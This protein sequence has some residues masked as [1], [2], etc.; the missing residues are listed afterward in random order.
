MKIIKKITLS[1]VITLLVFL[2]FACGKVNPPDNPVEVKE[3]TITWVSEGETLKTDKVKEG[4]MPVYVGEVPSKPIGKGVEYTF[5][6]WVP[7]IVAAVSDATYTAEFTSTSRR[8]P[9][10]VS[11]DTK[12]FPYDGEEHSLEVVNLPEGA[13]V[14]YVNNGRTEPG[15]Q[16][17]TAIISYYGVDYEYA[18]N[19]VIEKSASIL[20]IESS[21]TVKSGESIKYTLNNDEQEIKY[22]PIYQPGKYLVEI[23]ALASDHYNES[24]RYEVDVIVED[25]NPFGIIFPSSCTSYLEGESVTLTAQNIPDGYTA[26]YENNVATE[27]GKQHVT[28]HIFD[29]NNKEVATLKTIWTID[30]HKNDDFNAF[31]DQL[32]VDYLSDDFTAWNAFIRHPEALGYDRSEYGDAAWY[33]Y[34]PLTEEDRAEAIEE[35]AEIRGRFNVFDRSK[36]SLSQQLGYD[37]AKELLDDLD[38][39]WAGPLDGGLEN[40]T[41]IDSYGG[42]VG[43]LNSAVENYILVGEQEIQDVINYIKSGLDCFPSYLIWAQD[44]I[45]AGFPLSNYTLDEMIK[46][47]TEILEPEDGSEYFLIELL[48]NKINS[49]DF[50][51]D[52]KKSEYIEQLKDA[53]ENYYFPGL[54]ILKDGLEP[55]KGHIVKEE[56]EGYW[57]KYE[58][59]ADRY[60]KKLRSNIG[61]DELTIEEYLFYVNK[62]MNSNSKRINEI[63]KEYRAMNEKNRTKWLN[64]VEGITPFVNIED[65]NEMVDYLKHFAK[66][67]VPQLE[68][69]I[70]VH[71]KYMDRIQGSQTTTQA[72][73]Y[74]SALDEF[75]EEYIT[76][77]PVLI[78]SDLNECL[79]TMA[80]EGYPGHL[81]AHVLMKEMD[82]HYI[83]MIFDSTGFAEGWAKYVELMLKQ[84][85]LEHSDVSSSDR[86]L[87]E[88]AIEYLVCNS[89]AGYLVYCVVDE[90]A[91]YERK[92]ISEISDYVV[93]LGYGSS[94]GL[95]IYRTV[96]EN[97][98]VYNSYGFGQ[99]YMYDT[100]LTCQELLGSLYNEVDFNRVLLEKGQFDLWTIKDIMNDYVAD[101]LFL[102]GE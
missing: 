85:I 1:L 101:Q 33:I 46:F 58:D 12:K 2:S 54:V 99:I 52:A 80:H 93:D 39:D 51:D 23:Y 60:L 56:D 35:L 37:F 38:E 10:D 98:V 62:Y 32:L 69:D 84:Y 92:S 79:S 15:L 74:S 83:N 28:C 47:L 100:H 3:Y 20:T 86:K 29:S 91:H 22:T 44:K 78:G 88:L 102:Y 9:G 81:Y 21:Q 8:L 42:Y 6:N 63:I 65:P 26:I 55:L 11:F 76:L 30:Y 64:Y 18:A 36:L 41:Y 72:Y 96:I 48:C 34:D 71:V 73:Y 77:N 95:S 13:T 5:S 66:F 94:A 27:I 25:N 67:I 90:M 14:N 31:L 53:F 17:V 59:G 61:N 43:E 7:E 70:T 68:N 89:F 49:V 75:T 19:L 57:A 50:I 97:P 24:D 82:Y 40:I 4:E 87:M 45:D 16:K